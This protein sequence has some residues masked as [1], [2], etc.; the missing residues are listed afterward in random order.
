MNDTPVILVTG[1]SRGLGADI[2]RWLGRAG[3][4]VALVARSEAALADVARSVA[5]SGS[6]ALTLPA[7]VSGREACDRAVEK[8]LGR[9]GRL[10]GLVNNAGVLPP[11]MS[12]ERSDPEAWGRNI[13]VNLLGPYF[14]IRAAIPA[15]R[16]AGGRVV[17]ISSGAAVKPIGAWSAYCAAKAALTHL[18]AV[19]AVEEP[20]IIAVALRPGVIDTEMQALIRREGPSAMDPERASYFTKLKEEGGLEPPW[21][22]ARSAAWLALHAPPSLSGRFVE[23]DDPRV[24]APALAFFGQSL[25]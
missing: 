11:V 10:D 24:A 13:A 12:I 7:D 22:P 3:V 25:S 16:A 21:V 19:V 20:R 15:L 9:F 4:R 18:T 14:L 5:A 1:A 8:T 17:N 6:E 2:A 23:Y